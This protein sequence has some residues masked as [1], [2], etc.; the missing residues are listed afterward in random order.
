MQ[1]TVSNLMKM[2]DS[3]QKRVKNTVGKGEIAYNDQF[4]FFPQCFLWQIRKNQ[5]LFGI[6]LNVTHNIKL[7][8]YKLEKHCKKRRK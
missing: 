3:S 1:T 6:G 8:F 4:L 7:V 5:G 2:A